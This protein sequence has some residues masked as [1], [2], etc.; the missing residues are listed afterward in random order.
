M[1]PLFLL[2]LV[3][4]RL[5]GG[6]DSSEGRVEVLHGGIWG[7]VCDDDFDDNDATV[8]C[9]MLGYRY[10]SSFSASN[11]DITFFGIPKT[12]LIYICNEVHV[13]CK[14]HCA[15]LTK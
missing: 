5:A 3:D 6:N 10:D 4:L 13:G 2:F 15:I 9:R 14:E 1:Y 8:I 11:K 12:S 7:T